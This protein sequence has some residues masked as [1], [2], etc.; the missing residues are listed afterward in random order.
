VQAGRFRTSLVLR[1]DTTARMKKRCETVSV[2]QR[3][4]M[5]MIVHPFDSQRITATS[6]KK[7]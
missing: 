7:H 1:R 3:E 2:I 5:A 6:Q 4:S